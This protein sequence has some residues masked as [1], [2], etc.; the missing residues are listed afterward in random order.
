[1][2]SHRALEDAFLA[3]DEA[4]A[5]RILADNYKARE[6]LDLSSLAHN[7]LASRSSALTLSDGSTTSSNAALMAMVEHQR[8][9]G[10]AS[11]LASGADVNWQDPSR[12][13]AT[14]LAIAA[15]LR[16]FEICLTLLA[17]GADEN[18]RNADGQKACDL[19]S[20][21]FWQSLTMKPPWPKA[22]WSATTPMLKFRSSGSYT[23]NSVHIYCINKEAINSC[24]F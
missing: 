8:L 22:S 16:N 17:F 24:K 4:S 10:V 18:L 5:H 19:C 1:M 7:D 14:P 20:K 23:E 21:E 9:H 11:L 13:L 15:K 12:K 3:G 2:D 6:H